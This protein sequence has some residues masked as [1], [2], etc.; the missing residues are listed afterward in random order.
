MIFPLSFSAKNKFYS[1][2]SA[3]IFASGVILFTMVMK[4]APFKSTK[5]SDEFY[6]L[7][8]TDKDKYWQIFS[9][10]NNCPP[11]HFKDLM[12]KMLDE[13]PNKRLSLD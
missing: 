7:M 9:E 2:E 8:K 11:I 5:A 1:P 6:K 12:E 3:D 13:N 10:L 4:S